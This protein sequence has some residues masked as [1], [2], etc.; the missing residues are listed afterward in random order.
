MTLSKTLFCS[1]SH[2]FSVQNIGY[3]ICEMLKALLRF[4]KVS[5]SLLN[6][7]FR[8]VRHEKHM[9][10]KENNSDGEY[11]LS[12]RYVYLAELFIPMTLTSHF[13]SVS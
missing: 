9:T 5:S 1:A 12:S 6:V 3:T 4:Y 11:W 2:L 7:I 10:G 8:H 13:S